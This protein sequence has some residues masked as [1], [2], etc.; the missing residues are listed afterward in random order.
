[1]ASGTLYRTIGRPDPSAGH[2]GYGPDSSTGF[3][4]MNNLLYSRMES[5]HPSND[6]FYD[7]DVNVYLAN[8]LESFMKPG[9]HEMLTEYIVPWDLPLFETVSCQDDPRVKYMTYRLNADFIMIGLG[10]FNNPRGRRPSSTPQFEH[11]PGI[12]AG[13]AK[14]YYGLAQSYCYKTFRRSTAMGDVMGKLSEGFEKYIKVLATLKSEYFNIFDKISSGQLYHLEIAV[15][16]EEMRQSITS[17]HDDFLDA[18]SDYMKE[19][20]EGSRDR[21]VAAAGR[22]READPAFS[23]DIDRI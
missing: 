11:G 16:K 4:M 10:I 15:R 22:I 3:F 19:R 6:G 9:Y 1:M 7:E 12:Y 8:M 2:P 21:L 5:G 18:Y 23:F 20:S 13:R 14:A 17:L